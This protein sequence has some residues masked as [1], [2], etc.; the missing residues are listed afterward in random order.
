MNLLVKNG[1]VVTGEEVLKEDIYIHEDKISAIGKN[2]EKL[3][4]NNE[5][6]NIID[7]S[8]CYVFPGVIDPHVQL[9]GS[10]KNTVMTDDFYTGTKAAA[11]G[12]I[13]TIIDFAVQN[14]GNLLLDTFFNRKNQADAKVCIDYTLHVGITDPT[15]EALAEINKLTKEGITSFKTYMTYRD[16]GRMVD[17]AGLYRIMGEVAKYN[18]IVEVHQENN[19]L[20]EYMTDK[21]QE[22]GKM[23]SSFFPLS[24]TEVVEGIATATAILLARDANCDLYIHHVT[25]KETI[26]M[27][28]WGVSK[29]ITVFGETCPHYLV[30]ND[31]VYNSDF[32]HRYIMNPPI[33]NQESQDIL[34]EAIKKDYIQTIGTDH[35]SYSLIQKDKDKSNFS[36]VPAG[37]PGIET[38]LPI[39]YTFSVNKGIPVQKIVKLLSE[40]PAKIFG[41]FPR[42]GMIRIGSDADLVIYD[43]KSENIIKAD[44]L[45]LKTDFNPFEGIKIRGEVKATIL[46]GKVIV[47]DKNFCGGKGEGLF[48]NGSRNQEY[49][50]K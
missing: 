25:S 46:R 22:E 33:R 45:H 42:K 13:T 37:V 30:L 35:C 29:G 26:E 32:G 31:S 24:R 19:N 34:W 28:E 23:S 4:N 6:S 43:T 15:Q 21:L 39:I 44:N 3:I 50:I 36:K 2:L 9:E 17:E 5:R 20:V 7:A 38:L 14:K 47:K 49:L 27:I 48:I 8:N 10:Y 40:N 11:F 1:L 12:G 41:L 18:G 16:R